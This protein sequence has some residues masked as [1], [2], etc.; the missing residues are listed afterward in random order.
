MAAVLGV[1]ARTL[2][3]WR[4]NS[5]C[6]EPKKPGRRSC[7]VSI[8]EMLTIAREW[9]QQG[10][11]GSRPV[12]AALPQLRV[13]VIRRVVAELK[14]RSQKRHVKI[15]FKNRISVVVKKAGVFGAIDAATIQKGEDIIVYR[16]RGNL[17]VDSLDCDSHTRSSDVL[18]ILKNLKDQGKLPFVL[19]SDNGSPF[20]ARD[21]EDFLE[22]NKVIQLRS[23]P[24][25]PQH[26][27]SAENAVLEIKQLIGQSLNPSE[28]IWV[29]NNRRRRAKLGW[30]TSSEMTQLNPQSC[31]E[32]ERAMFYSAACEAIRVAELGKK[33]S[34]ELRKTKRE[35]IFQTLE[36]FSFI[37][38]T[39]GHLTPSL[40][41]E[42]NS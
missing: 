41:A 3:N 7:K 16:D 11:P 9:E 36:R 32:N 19:S 39:R 27:G 12:I 17:E 5:N 31:T 29:L 26:N 25:V 23:L 34:C 21:V 24:R 4:N 2:R 22:E 28:A 37:T 6:L 18:N 33:S 15:R 8:S 13:R 1:S 30:K 42:V 20:C 40:K 35:A 14:K 38:R 10:R